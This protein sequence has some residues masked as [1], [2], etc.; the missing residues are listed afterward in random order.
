[1]VFG[2]EPDEALSEAPDDH[3]VRLAGDRADVQGDVRARGDHV[4]LGFPFSRSYQ[5]GYGR[6]KPRVPENRFLAVTLPPLPLEFFARPHD[7]AGEQI[8]PP[9]YR[10]P[11]RTLRDAA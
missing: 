5:Y 8:T 3:F 2:F 9:R 4:D 10:S 7:P 6:L 1:M 11:A